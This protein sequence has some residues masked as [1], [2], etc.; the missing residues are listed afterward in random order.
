MRVALVTC[1]RLSGLDPD[2]E[3]LRDALVEKGASVGVP[4]WDDPA[5]DWKAYDVVFLRSTWDYHLRREAFLSWLESIDPVTRLV[6]SPGLVR[7][8]SHKS[9]L[10]RLAA[11]GAPVIPTV[12]LK[13]GPRAS[14]HQLLEDKGWQDAVAKPAVG[15]DSFGIVRLQPGDTA[16]EEAALR[17]LAERDL[18]V[19]PYVPSVADHGERCL[20]VIDGEISHA[21]RKN[22]FF[23]GGRHAGPEGRAVPVADDERDAARAVLACA[24]AELELA[25]VRPLIRYAR[26]DLARDAQG[27]PRLMELELVEPTLFFSTHPGSADRMAQGLLREGR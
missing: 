2:D 11:A 14:L 20:V 4:V 5:V 24:R 16:S 6:H 17:L 27:V 13:A 3:P 18:L 1:A 7:W 12:V 25:G 23:L 8:N 19:Q 26:V 22:S 21:V 15:L 10:T 9:Y